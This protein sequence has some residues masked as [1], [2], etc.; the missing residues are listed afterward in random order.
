MLY[1]KLIKQYLKIVIIIFINNINLII[2]YISTINNYKKLK[3][4]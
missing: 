3:K 4:V 1:K 2:I